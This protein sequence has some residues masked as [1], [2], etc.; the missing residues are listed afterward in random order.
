MN[1]TSLCYK[2]GPELPFL[3][4]TTICVTSGRYVTFY[5][6]RV[7]GVTYPEGY[8]TD[9]VFTELCEVNI[10]GRQMLFSDSFLQHICII[11]IYFYIYLPITRSKVE[12]FA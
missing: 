4:F 3:N 5:N 9:L 7:I 2:D 12:Y 8:Q 10:Q 11:P 6:E 1:S